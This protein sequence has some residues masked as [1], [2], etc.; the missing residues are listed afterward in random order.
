[1][2][3]TNPLFRAISLTVGVALF[4][5]TGTAVMIAG[6]S[7]PTFS[8][9]TYGP[10]DQPVVLTSAPEATQ[11]LSPA[12]DDDVLYQRIARADGTHV[13]QLTPASQATVAQTTPSSGIVAASSRLE[14]PGFSRVSYSLQAKPAGFSKAL[15]SCNSAV[16]R[17]SSK[18]ETRSAHDAY[19]LSC[20]TVG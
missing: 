5:V 6:F 20:S 10:Y 15:K 2:K 1:M 7:D 14:A 13:W 16:T 19:D 12:G 17:T 4:A 3:H 18:P 11:A 9:L 8:T